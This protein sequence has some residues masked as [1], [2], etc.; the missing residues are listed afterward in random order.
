[1]A[2]SLGFAR[3]DGGVERSSGPSR[4]NAP[5]FPGAFSVNLQIAQLPLA[6]FIPAAPEPGPAALFG[7][8]RLF[9]PLIELPLLPAPAEPPVIRPLEDPVVMWSRDMLPLLVL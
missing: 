4:K 5:V 7:L 6:Y 3:R 2:A 9:E 1:M 8:A